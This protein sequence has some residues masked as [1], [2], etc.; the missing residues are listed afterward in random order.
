VNC[1]ICAFFLNLIRYHHMLSVI[2][3][4][5]SSGLILDW[6]CLSCAAKV[7]RIGSEFRV[8]KETSVEI[9]IDLNGNGICDCDTGIPFLDHMLD[10]S[11]Y[12]CSYSAPQIRNFR[13][14]H[15]RLWYWHSLLGPCASCEWLVLFILCTS[16]TG[17]PQVV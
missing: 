11:D 2:T 13:S 9:N 1:D 3:W 4:D 16:N 10:V 12:F 5:C 14:L 17:L 8:T 15:L 7:S 6:I